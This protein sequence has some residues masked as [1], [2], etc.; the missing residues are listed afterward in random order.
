[1]TLSSM[2]TAVVTV[3]LSFL[4]S[5]PSFVVWAARF[6]EPKLHT[7]VSLLDVFKRISVHKLELWMVPTWSCGERTLEGSFHVI[8][9]CPVSKSIFNI[10]RQS[11]MA[12]STLN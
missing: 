7:A 8:H 3:S 5:N 10:L 4:W 9:G 1:M 6:T 11:S 2:R 12:G